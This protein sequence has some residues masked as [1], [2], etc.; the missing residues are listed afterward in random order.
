M[1]K[2]IFISLVILVIS[3]FSFAQDQKAIVLAEFTKA[4]LLALGDLKSVLSAINKGQ[5]Y[6]KYMVRNFK[7]TTS[8]T[9]AD[10]TVTKYSEMGPGGLWSDKQK[11]IIDQYATKGVVF[12]LENIVMVESGKKGKVDQPDVSFM[13]KH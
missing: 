10:K 7:L 8:V 12:T 9:N 2:S 6:S 4:E 11:A 1:K 13:I 3:T 5:D